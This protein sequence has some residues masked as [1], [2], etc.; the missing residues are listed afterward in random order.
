MRI[1]LDNVEPQH[2]GILRELAGALYFMLTEADINSKLAEIDH[3][4][5]RLEGNQ[6][7]F[8]S[9]DWAIIQQDAV[10][11]KRNGTSALTRMPGMNLLIGT[12]EIVKSGNELLICSMKFAGH[13][14][15]VRANRN[16]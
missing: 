15:R 10:S 13:R 16:S 5:Q 9:P 3:R 7:S 2:I 4:I 6:T 1:V 8:V 11:D 14:L 12:T